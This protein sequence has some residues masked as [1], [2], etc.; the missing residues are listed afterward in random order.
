MNN[1]PVDLGMF[2]YGVPLELIRQFTGKLDAAGFNSAWY[3]EITYNDAFTPIAMAGIE[4]KH[5]Q[6]LGTA[7]IGPWARSPVVTA[8]SCASLQE[9][10]EGRMVLGLGTQAKNYVQSWHGRTYQK[11][12]L[13]MREYIDITKGLWSG[14]EYSFQGEI[15]SVKDF[16]LTYPPAVKIPIYMAAIGPKMLELAGEIADGV[17]GCFW[18]LEYTRDIA[19]PNIR[20]GLLKSG[21]DLQDF[22][23]A[24]SMSTL[25]T[26]DDSAL[27]LQKGQFMQYACADKSSPAYASSVIAAGFED[28]LTVVRECVTAQNY[29]KAFEVISEEMVDALTLSGTATHIER[30]MNEYQKLGIDEIHFIPVEAGTFHRL[31]EGHLPGAKLPEHTGEGYIRAMDGLVEAFSSK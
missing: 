27:G 15:F 1:Q 6:K 14:E 21:R 29:K 7:V 5:L 13:A 16:V 20:K 3:P 4:S 12:L 28:Q 9:V 26:T 11:P 24:L 30:K 18:S 22:H 8:L 17:I 10:T 31:Y 25:V 23:I 2:L 19:I